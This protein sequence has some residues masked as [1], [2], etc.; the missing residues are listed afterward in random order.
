MNNKVKT[1]ICILIFLTGLSVMLYPSISNYFHQKNQVGVIKDY[2]E[3]VDKM[4]REQ[5]D[6]MKNAA[7]EYNAR[8][9]DAAINYN[10]SSSSAGPDYMN[11]L[12]V[13]DDVMAYISIPICG[14][15]LP[16]RHGCSEEVLQK[17]AGHLPGSSLPI[18]GENTHAVIT[19]HRGLPSAKLF[20]NIDSLKLGDQ[21]Y[22]HGLDETLAYE[23]DQ[24]KVVLP[25]DT[26]DLQIMKGGD[27]VTLV[28][29]TPY[30]INTHRLLVR[31]KRTEYVP[32]IEEEQAAQ[33]KKKNDRMIILYVIGIIVAALVILIVYLVWKRLVKK[34]LR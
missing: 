25:E 9:A 14:I 8:I 4:S 7:R 29:C 3:K 30:G 15:N 21:F 10:A 13:N 33:N 18:G 31:G 22:I 16:I 24:I 28:T 32:Q 23:V 12:S 5:I 34:K 11:L 1:I 6:E 26:K 20:T 17:S 19:A 2:R 27:Y